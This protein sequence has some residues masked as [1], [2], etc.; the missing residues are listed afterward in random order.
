[1][2]LE[3]HDDGTVTNK[4]SEQCSE[5]TCANGHWDPKG[6]TGYEVQ[7]PG[8]SVI[9]IHPTP[10]GPP[11]KGGCN[12]KDSPPVRFE[13]NGAGTAIWIDGGEHFHR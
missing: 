10:D 7:L 12:C 11:A 6:D 4:A 5:M 1:M 8:A 13:R 2:T 3:F 9:W